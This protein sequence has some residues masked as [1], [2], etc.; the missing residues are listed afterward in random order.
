MTYD[1]ILV[2]PN[3][4]A[5]V[6][7]EEMTYVD[8]GYYM[9]NYDCKGLAFAIGVTITASYSAIYTALACGSSVLIASLSSVP[10]IGTVIAIVGAA[11]FIGQAKEFTEAFC[12]ALHKGKGINITL[13]WYWCIPKAKFTVK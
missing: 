12:G 9:S 10:V 8:G 4:Y 1:G 13:G 2:M 6:T 5:V 11:Y 7:E 3:N